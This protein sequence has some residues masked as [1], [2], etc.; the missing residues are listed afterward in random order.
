MTTDNQKDNAATT[1][2]EIIDIVAKQRDFFKTK[3][4]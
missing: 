4:I 2:K 1:E 3:I